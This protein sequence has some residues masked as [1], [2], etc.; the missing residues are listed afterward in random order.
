MDTRL[1]QHEPG[2]P[3][4]CAPQQQDGCLQQLLQQWSEPQDSLLRTALQLLLASKPQFAK[5]FTAELLQELAAMPAERALLL[6][7]QLQHTAGQ[8]H[9]VPVYL[10]RCGQQVLEH[11]ALLPSCGVAGRPELWRAM[12]AGEAAQKV[13]AGVGCASGCEGAA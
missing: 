5:Q 8:L 13:P 11:F 2:F 7:C 6:L 9:S 3:G 4:L 1:Q 12:A 10:R